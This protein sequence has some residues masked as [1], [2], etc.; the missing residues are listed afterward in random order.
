MASRFSAY[1]S[2]EECGW[3]HLVF[4][5]MGKRISVSLETPFGNNP[6]EFDNWLANCARPVDMAPA[7]N[8]A[9]GLANIKII[10]NN[11]STK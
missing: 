1:L 7:L 8:Q 9:T 2:R 6:K 3:N 5:D 11:K 4:H 10:V